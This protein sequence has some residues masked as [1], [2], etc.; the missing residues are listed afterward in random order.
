MACRLVGAKPLS[1]Q[2]LKIVN[3]ALR[4]KLLWNFKR[5]SYIFIHENAFENDACE[6]AAMLSHCVNTRSA[7]RFLEILPSIMSD[8]CGHRD[9]KALAPCTCMYVLEWQLKNEHISWTISYHSPLV[10]D[11]HIFGVD[12]WWQHYFNTP[13]RRPSCDRK[14]GEAQPEEAAGAEPAVAGVTARQ[15]W[16]R[17]VERVVWGDGGVPSY[18][19]GG[20]EWGTAAQEGI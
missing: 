16:V 9:D 10:S 7:A 18:T 8:I 20:G 2:V 17:W 14:Y 4:N 11:S 5:N 12:Y 1:D 19:C 3:W 6:M 15:G 13:A